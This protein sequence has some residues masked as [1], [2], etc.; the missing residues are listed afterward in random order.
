MRYNIRLAAKKGV[1][2]K[3]F[4]VFIFITAIYMGAESLLSP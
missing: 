2:N 1:L 4:A 3:V